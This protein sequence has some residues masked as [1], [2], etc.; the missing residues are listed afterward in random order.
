M[1]IY[2]C[3]L[4]IAKKLNIPV[5]GVNT[6]RSWYNVELVMRNAHHPADVPFELIESW[7]FD[8]F[9]H[10]VINVWSYA[11]VKYFWVFEVVPFLQRFHRE[12][13]EMLEAYEG[14][15]DIEPVLMFSNG[16]HTILPRSQNPNVIEIG[17]IQVKPAK[18]F[19]EVKI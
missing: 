8:D 2:Q 7:K 10:R 15:L 18:L 5:I 1:Q 4:P 13:E 3:F 19:P 16:H 11:V 9:Y 14:Y 12:N 6:V 17:G